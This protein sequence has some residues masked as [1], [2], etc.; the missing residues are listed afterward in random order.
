MLGLSVLSTPDLDSRLHQASPQGSQGQEIVMETP[1]D[2]K[3]TLGR[4]TSTMGPWEITT[5]DQE[6][7][8][9]GPWEIA[10]PDRE[11]ATMG[12]WEIAMPDRETATMGV[13]EIA[14]H[15]KGSQTDPEKIPP[16]ESNKLFQTV[17]YGHLKQAHDKSTRRVLQI[18]NTENQ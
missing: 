3:S 12:P 18:T 11:T 13:W 1:R 2:R 6:T 16:Q 15:Q 7:A 8:T 5:P 17:R 14:T 4:E 10:M 9:M